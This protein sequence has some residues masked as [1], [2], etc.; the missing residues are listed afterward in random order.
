MKISRDSIRLVFDQSG[1][2][3]RAEPNAFS[4]GAVNKKRINNER[5]F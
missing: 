1:T 3:E 5:H 2:L 4:M